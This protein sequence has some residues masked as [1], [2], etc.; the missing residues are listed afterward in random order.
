[1][2][3]DRVTGSLTPGKRA[4]ILLVATDAPGMLPA[5][6][7]YGAVLFHA[8]AGDIRTALCDGRIVKQDGRLAHPGAAAAFAR[9]A[10]RAAATVE[11]ARA[12]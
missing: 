1:M 4:D 8:E 10:E 11:R 5:L 3:L 9:A 7:P 12:G 6:D 2:G